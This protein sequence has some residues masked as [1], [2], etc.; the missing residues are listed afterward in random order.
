M[1]TRSPAPAHPP[2]VAD[3]GSPLPESGGRSDALQ[4]E[5]ASATP[6]GPRIAPRIA[7]SGEARARAVSAADPLCPPLAQVQ[8]WFTR[9]VTHPKSVE[10]GV[11]EARELL[12][13]D[14][15]AAVERIVTAGPR[16][17]ATERLGIYQFAYHA[18]LGE[19]LADD[20]P[21][22]KH[23]LG[24]TAFESLA[25]RYIEAHPSNDPNLNGFGRHFASFAA[26]EAGCLEHADFAA[27][28]AR[29]EWAIVE[30]LHA[31]ASAP[32]SLSALQ[33]LAPEQWAGIKLTPS[34]TLRFQELC[35]PVNRYFQSVKNGE[36]TGIP[37][38]EWSATAIYR[39]GHTIWRMDFTLAM[40]GVLNALLAGATLSDALDT[41]QHR[42]DAE[43]R[44]PGAIEEDVMAWFRA[45]V[46]GGFFSGIEC[47]PV[48]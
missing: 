40:A 9:V 44:E 4:I 25:R 7:S 27:D 8:A 14:R 21:V 31:P 39:E 32:L 46:S 10:A 19:C 17:S 28:L 24:E 41:L 42:P 43:Q 45:W 2:I 47:P 3:D 1:S 37:S 5:R 16:L 38:R 29:L 18:R 11:D 26:E 33:D 23:A 20:Y 6:I 12:G 13:E 22:L 30:V 34:S 35:F 48:A 15:S 36:A